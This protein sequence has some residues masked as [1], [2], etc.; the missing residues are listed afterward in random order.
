MPMPIM[1]ELLSSYLLS[2]DWASPKPF[3]PLLQAATIDHPEAE[4]QK[5]KF[6][7]IYALEPQKL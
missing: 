5:I 3:S 6:I 2:P 1:A 4:A 7:F